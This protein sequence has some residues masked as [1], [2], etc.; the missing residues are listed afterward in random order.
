MIT[1]GTNTDILMDILMGI[2]PTFMNFIRRVQINQLTITI[3]V[4]KPFVVVIHQM[5]SI[6]QRRELMTIE[7]T[8]MQVSLTQN[9]CNHLF[10]SN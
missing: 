8:P 3:K 6:G 7:T 5:K 9:N 4:L 10:Q 1:M 2:H